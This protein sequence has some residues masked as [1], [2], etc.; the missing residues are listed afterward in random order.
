MSLKTSENTVYRHENMNLLY[1]N[2][3]SIYIYIYHFLRPHESK[4]LK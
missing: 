4:D 3:E 1:Q 2:L